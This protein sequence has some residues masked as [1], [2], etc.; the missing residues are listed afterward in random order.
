MVKVTKPCFFVLLLVITAV[1]VESVV[2]EPEP[3]NNPDQLPDT[4]TPDTA[5]PLAQKAGIG[6]RT[7]YDFAPGPKNW[8]SCKI[9]DNASNLTNGGIRDEE[10]IHGRANYQGSE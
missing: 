1:P 6:R 7:L 3:V 5:A 9:S 8:S 10:A 4:V 2:A